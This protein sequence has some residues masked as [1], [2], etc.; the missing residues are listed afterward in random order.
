MK[1]KLIKFFQKFFQYWDRN[2]TA[3]ESTEK[4]QFWQN[5]Y[6]IDIIFH[7]FI[8]HITKIEKLSDH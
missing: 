3:I 7:E 8:N 1:Q 6:F 4:N 5:W 2:H